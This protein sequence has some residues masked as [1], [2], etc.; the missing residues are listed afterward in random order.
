MS[1]FTLNYIPG[2]SVE[3]VCTGET[4]YSTSKEYQL[5]KLTFTN[6][7]NLVVDLDELLSIVDKN[8]HDQVVAQAAIAAIQKELDAVTAERDSLKAQVEASVSV[9]STQ[10][11][12]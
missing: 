3:I 8:E 6:G 1:S 12:P 7:G 5:Q 10:V 9:T 4:G 11:T 2:Q